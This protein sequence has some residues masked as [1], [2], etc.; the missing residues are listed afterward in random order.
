MTVRIF[1]VKII[2]VMIFLGDF[3]ALTPYKLYQLRYLVELA[4][5]QGVLRESSQAGRRHGS[6]VLAAAFSNSFGEGFESFYGIVP[7]DAGIGDGLTAG[8]FGKIGDEFLV[9]LDEVG[10]DH[11]GGDGF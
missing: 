6:P 3:A 11:H 8:E 9:T 7:V 5:A 2:K 1:L 10:F 4:S